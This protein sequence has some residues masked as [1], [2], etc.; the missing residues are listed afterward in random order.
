MLQATRFR[1]TQINV[2]EIDSHLLEAT[3]GFLEVSEGQRL[4]EV[5]LEASSFGPCLEVGSYCGKSAMYIGAACRR[6]N[7]IL[8]SIDHHRGSE[9]HQPGQEYFDPAHF[10]PR[11]H[12]IDTLPSFRHTLLKANLED[13]VV[14]IVCR[15]EVA[16]KQWATLLSL[17][18]IDGSHSYKAVYTDFQCWHPKLMPG[19]FLLVHDIFSDPTKGGQ[20]PYQVYQHALQSD[21]FEV[22]PMTGT[23]GV[24]KRK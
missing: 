1:L 15:S 19:G 9:E 12:Q 18:F 2:M 13:T 7:S 23:L 5:A 6:N 4:Y 8:F 11:Q 3:E 14:P 24:L 10:D 20:A 16:A 21:L 17:V 22:L